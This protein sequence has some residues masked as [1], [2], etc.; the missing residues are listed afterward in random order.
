MPVIQLPE[1]D[2]AYVTIDEIRALPNLAD[3]TRFT[4]DELAQARDWFE[5]TFEDYVG[6]AF[7]PR[8]ATERLSGR[9][10]TL[11]LR[12]WPVRSITAVR[13]YTTASAYTSFTTDE[14]ADL[15]LDP[16]GEVRR[17]GL[18]AWPVD[19]EVEYVHGQESPPADVR[20][21]ALVAIQ[22]K[23]M[24]DNSG[25]PTDRTY[26]TATDGV[27]IRSILPGPDKPF[28]LAS[29]DEVAGRYRAKYKLPA[30]A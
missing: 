19:V 27:F 8:T 1:A 13:S 7:V 23:L 5:T 26:G 14:L 3:T 21:A 12:H 29:V 18:G 16:T 6:M 4:D 30:I 24:E 15:L 11:M 2:N 17:Y 28:G 10:Y 20:K 25:R 9:C 22:E